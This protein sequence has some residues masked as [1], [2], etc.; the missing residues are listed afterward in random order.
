VFR[1]NRYNNTFLSDRT[2]AEFVDDGYA[3]EGVFG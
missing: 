2:I 1:T 3:R